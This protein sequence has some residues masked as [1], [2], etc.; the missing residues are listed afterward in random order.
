M[1]ILFHLGAHA[2][3]DG[4]LIRSILRNRARLA[5]DG[6][7]V[8]GPGRYRELLGQVSTRL[9]GAAAD[10]DTEAMLLEVIRDD[11]TADRIVLSNENFLC[12]REMALSSEGLY[13]KAAKSGWLRN[14]FP[15]HRV[16]F[17][18]A[19]R[20][21]ATLIP[22]LLS[23]CDEADRHEILR[24]L[25][26]DQL[27]WAD[28]VAE[29]LEANP[30]CRVIAWCHEDSPFIWAEIMR[31]ITAH[32]PFLELDGGFDMLEQI[33][34]KPGLTRLSEFLAAHPDLTEARKR[35]AVSAFL[36]A[37][38]LSDAI[39]TEIDLPGWTADTVRA[40]THGYDEDVSRVAALP[41]V[42]FIAP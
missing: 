6:I 8:P 40:L 33:M 34:S 9:R 30:G 17:A 25:P 38:A 28:V 31:E 26:L 19:L 39:E 18:L 12:R 14:C 5:E 24:D 2:T 32:D 21:P 36:D 27:A 41:G 29:I 23:G 37:H 1:D 13:A 3:D 11:D 42:T 22:A 35:Q 16:E 15:G 7:G 10:A 4:L 20:N